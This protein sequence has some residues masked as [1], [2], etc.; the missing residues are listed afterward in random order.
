MLDEHGTKIFINEITYEGLIERVTLANP[1]NNNLAGYKVALYKYNDAG[2]G[3]QTSVS[4][5]MPGGTTDA[6]ITLEIPM[7][8]KVFRKA[9]HW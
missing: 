1:E 9:S 7:T 2:Q 6:F 8:E 5:R 3:V 4:A